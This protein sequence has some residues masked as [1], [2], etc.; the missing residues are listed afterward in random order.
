MVMGLTQVILLMTVITIMKFNLLTFNCQV[1]PG[2]AFNTNWGQVWSTWVK[3]V[4]VKD[5]DIGA[6][7][8]NLSYNMHH[9]L[10]VVYSD[11]G[12]GKTKEEL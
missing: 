12:G 2:G 6:I 7:A 1:M 8:I 9:I 3:L 11:N 10:N 5:R 4:E